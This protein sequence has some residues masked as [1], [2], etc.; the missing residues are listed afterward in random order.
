MFPL[1][2]LETAAN[3]AVF[4]NQAHDFPKT[5][6]YELTA[7]DRLRITLAGER[8]GRPATEVFDLTRVK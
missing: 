5:F 4:E 7:P 3:R 8:K 2:K 1:V 6:A